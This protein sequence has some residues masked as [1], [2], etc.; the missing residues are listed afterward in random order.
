M[1]KNYLNVREAAK[2]LDVSTSLIYQLTSQK[3]VKFYKPNGSSRVYFTKED[4]DKYIK[5]D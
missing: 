3:R 1:E 4:L 5:N 2:Y